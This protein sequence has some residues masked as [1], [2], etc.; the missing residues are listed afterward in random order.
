[1]NFP[2]SRRRRAAGAA[3]AAA[4]TLAYC[5]SLAARE[6]DVLAQL[7]AQLPGRYDN[8]AQAEGDRSGGGAGHAAIE[9]LIAR[10]PA[11]LVGDTV[12]YVRETAADDPRR[13]LSQRL[14][15]LGAAR[16]GVML[17]VFRF[18]EPGRWRDGA[19]QPELFRALLLRDLEVLPGCELHWRRAGGGFRGAN[20]PATCAAEPGAA[21]GARLEQVLELGPGTLSLVERRRDAAG[22]ADG[23]DVGP[24]LFRRL[25]EER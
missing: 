15:V 10:V 13:V 23:A 12:F 1:M 3:L 14:W 6:R 22:R 24:Y 4:L 7:A 18:A 17:S 21:S 20:D 2:G 19:A 16:E 25:P 8:R 9:L 11:L 5:G